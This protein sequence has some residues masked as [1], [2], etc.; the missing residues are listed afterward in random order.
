M[1]IVFA[2]QMSQSRKQCANNVP[3]GEQSLFGREGKR[4]FGRVFLRVCFV[5]PVTLGEEPHKSKTV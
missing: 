3:L 1:K 4:L 5:G 2:P